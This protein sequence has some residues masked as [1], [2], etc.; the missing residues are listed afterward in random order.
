MKAAKKLQQQS[1]REQAPGSE[2]THQ[3]RLAP[4]TGTAAAPRIPRE[5]SVLIGG[6][7]ETHE[8]S[9]M[10]CTFQQETWQRMVE[11]REICGINVCLGLV[12]L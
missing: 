9:I 11:I 2:P 1:C 10:L 8:E 5:E 7:K 3:L 4:A 12:C 6:W